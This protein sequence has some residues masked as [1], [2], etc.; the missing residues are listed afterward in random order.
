[1]VPAA[2][3][4]ERV[5]R[6][7]VPYDV[8]IRDGVLAT[9]PGDITDYAFIRST[10]HELAERYRIREI[11]Y[12]RWNASQLVVD[13]G[14]DGL[15]MVRFG[16]AASPEMAAAVREFERLYLAGRLRTGGDPLLRWMAS[17]LAW[18]QD[19]AGNLFPDR[20]AS[21]DKIDGIVGLLMAIGRAM[22]T[23]PP[24]PPFRSAYETMGLTFAR[25]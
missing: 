1:L 8:W 2:N 21:A 10:V 25:S 20:R 5:R 18:R 22:T 13:L 4:G 7:G 14:N 9:T 15:T 17:N 11:A 12:D 19:A 16:Q 23:P 6:D 24:T 3:V